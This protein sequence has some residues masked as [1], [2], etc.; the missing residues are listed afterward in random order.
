MPTIQAR[1]GTLTDCFPGVVGTTD[2][3]TGDWIPRV[4][5]VAVWELEQVSGLTTV[6]ARCVVGLS[7]GAPGVIVTRINET[8]NE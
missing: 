2:G 8:R 1:V 6:Q 4:V 3:T 5:A 7:I